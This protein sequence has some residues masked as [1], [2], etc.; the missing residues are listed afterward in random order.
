M[1]T[2]PWSENYITMNSCVHVIVH[3][4]E[5]NHNWTAYAICHKLRSHYQIGI[6]L[7]DSWYKLNGYYAK[8]NHVYLCI[9]RLLDIHHTDIFWYNV[10]QETRSNPSANI[11]TIIFYYLKKLYGYIAQFLN[12]NCNFLCQ[13]RV[14]KNQTIR[15]MKW[16][17]FSMAKFGSKTCSEEENTLEKM[18]LK[19]ERP[20]LRGT[21]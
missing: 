13:R 5:N 14:E 12:G 21:Q 4:V 6:S 16:Q 3:C 7:S 1:N 9:F 8:V 20:E 11:V 17:Q 2:S 19:N 18:W 10:T 15:E